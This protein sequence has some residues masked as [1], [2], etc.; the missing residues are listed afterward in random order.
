MNLLGNNLVVLFFFLIIQVGFLSSW[1]HISGLLSACGGE[2]KAFDDTDAPPAPRSEQ[3][4]PRQSSLPLSNSSFVLNAEVYTTKGGEQFLNG[5]VIRAFREWPEHLP[6]PCPPS[7]PMRWWHPTE[8]RAPSKKG[9][10]FVKEMKTG[11][12]TV[13]GIVLRIARNVAKRTNNKN[14]MC[15]SR[16]DHSAARDMGYHERDPRESFLFTVIRNPQKRL[17]SQ[18]FHFFVSRQKMEPNDNNFQAFFRKM[19]YMQD[20]YLRDL[21]L[22]PAEQK[23]RRKFIHRYSPYNLAQEDPENLKNLRLG[24]AN[25][26]MRGY[27]FIGI[28]ERMDESLVVMMMLLRLKISDMLYIKAKSSGGF[29]DG[30]FNNT[31]TYIVPSFLSPG[32]KSYFK[33]DHYAERSLGDWI[34]Y[35]AANKSLDMTIDQLGPAKVEERL[36]QFRAAQKVAS[37]KCSLGIRYPCSVGGVRQPYRTHFSEHTDCLWLDSACGYECLDSLEPEIEEMIEQGRY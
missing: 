1:Q 18:F 11:S 26:I 32:M 4:Q 5:A 10:L 30:A 29:D 21:S 17:T 6:L 16:F 8:T 2:I 24:L 33:S 14:F 27:D 22:I 12:S 35:R 9:L 23:V 7:N 34:L 36:K 25:G 37:D 31:C 15:L 28:T 19:P 13:S 20:Y 3:S